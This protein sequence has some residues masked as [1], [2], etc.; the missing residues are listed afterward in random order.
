MILKSVLHT[1]ISGRM[2]LDSTIQLV[3]KELVVCSVASAHI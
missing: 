2:S 1:E 3:N